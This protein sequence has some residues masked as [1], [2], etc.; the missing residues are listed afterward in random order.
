MFRDEFEQLKE[1]R[2][3]LRYEI[4]KKNVEDSIPMPVNLPRVITNILSENKINSMTSVS[5]LDPRHYFAEMKNLLESVCVIPQARLG[6]HAK[7]SI[8]NEAH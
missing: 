7:D 6:T 2:R 1:D 4:L 3:A 5:D 8:I